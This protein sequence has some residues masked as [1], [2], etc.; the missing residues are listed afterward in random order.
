M[1][2][3]F[4]S[5]GDVEA[6][7]SCLLRNKL[8]KEKYYN[9][10]CVVRNQL[11]FS[12]GDYDG[13]KISEKIAKMRKYL[14]KAKVGKKSFVPDIVID[15]LSGAGK[16]SFL[17]YAELTYQPGFNERYFGGIPQRINDLI[18]KAEEEAKTPT[19]AFDAGVCKSA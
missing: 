19:S 11:R 13:F 1:L 12:P 2:D 3:H 14:G 7:F 17:I 8:I 16:E 4:N 6:I 10:E 18:L 5:Q 15:S 9:S